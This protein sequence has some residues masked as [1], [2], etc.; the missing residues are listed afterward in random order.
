MIFSIIALTLFMTVFITTNVVAQ[1]AQDLALAITLHADAEAGIPEVDRNGNKWSWEQLRVLRAFAKAI[2]SH[3]NGGKPISIAVSA[4]AGSGKTSLLQGMTHIVAKLCPELLTAMTAFNTHIAKSSKDILIQFQSSDGLNIK[5][6]G[7]SNTVNAGGHNLLSR[8][9]TGAGFSRI[10]YATGGSDRYLRLA[11][12]VLAGWLARE[13]RIPLLE[14]ARSNMEVKTTSHAMKD[15]SGTDGLLKVVSMA[16]QEGF[17]PTATIRSTDSADLP[18]PYVP[19]TPHEDDIKTLAE[20]VKRVGVNHH[21]MT[22]QPVIWATSPC[23]NWRLKSSPLLLKRASPP[24]KSFHIVARA[25]PAWMPSSCR[26]RT[27]PSRFH[28]GLMSSL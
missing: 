11:R 19:P 21:G 28:A 14:Q 1:S 17:V 8:M 23:L 9:A 6:F 2:H 15:I 22:I 20:I 7:S 13:D 10:D 12:I 16:T 26:K 18:S 27:I 3:N 4:V 25:R 24:S 5:V